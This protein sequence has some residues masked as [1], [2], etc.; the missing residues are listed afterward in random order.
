MQQQLA[1]DCAGDGAAQS[2][3]ST[4]QTA[5][6]SSGGG[7]ATDAQLVSADRQTHTQAESE[8]VAAQR[9]VSTAGRSLDAARSQLSNA[10]AR[11]TAYGQASV[12]TGLPRAGGIVA[13]GQQLCAIDGQPVLLLYGSAF[14]RRAFVPGMSPGADVAELNANLDALGY[15]HGLTGDAF[16]AATA[17]AIRA[18]AGRARESRDRRAAA[19]L[20]RVRA[21]PD[22]RDL[23]D[24]RPSRSARAWRQGRCCRPAGPA[25]QV[26]IQ[27]D[28]ALEGQVK[29]GD[30]VTITLPDNAD[31]AGTDH[32]RQLGRDNRPER[33]RRSP[34]RRAPD[35][36]GRDRRPRP[37][38]GQCVDHDRQRHATRWS[39][40]SMRCWRSPA[41]ATRS[42][43]SAAA[44]HHLVAV[45]PA[46]STTPTGLC[47][48]AAQV[49]RPAS[50]W[51]SRAYE[52]RADTRRASFGDRWRRRR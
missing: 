26:S 52:R 36:P 14:A 48:S 15:A 25:R 19:R 45:T 24:C 44:A 39:C 11:E 7:C 30:P 3:S 20:G 34:V 6:G 43:R 1:V 17:A 29:A 47:R 16:T 37:G 50:A 12:I 41:A 13:R 27:L 21:G 9:Q 10:R 46:C 33:D 4:T 49:L 31:H 5:T 51:W 35:R 8:A 40:R 38:A 18:A 28:A 23:A 32:L 2:A 22:P 42:R